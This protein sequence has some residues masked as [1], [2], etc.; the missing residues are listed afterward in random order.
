[1]LIRVVF[2]SRTHF[3]GGKVLFFHPN[4]GSVGEMKEFIEFVEFIEFKEFVEFIGS[5]G[6]FTGSF[7]GP[8][9]GIV[10]SIL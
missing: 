4:G 2:N 3:L 1:M 7:R 10:L 5:V 6:F 8:V 9:K